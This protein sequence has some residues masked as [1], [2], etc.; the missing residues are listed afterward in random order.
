MKLIKCRKCG[1]PVV[2]NDLMLQRLLDGMEEANKNALKANN[3]KQ[4]TAYIQQASQYKQLIKSIMHITQQ[5][6]K[7]G[8]YLE[9]EIKDLT[10]YLV[11]NNLM[12]YDEIGIIQ[13]KARERANKEIEEDKKKL[14]KLYKESHN[15]LFNKSK[16]DTTARSAIKLIEK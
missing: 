4:R 13:N 15:E 14:D 10:S 8:R 11:D 9:C 2:S 16:S 12:T 5:T 6:E 1:T 3:H 7:R